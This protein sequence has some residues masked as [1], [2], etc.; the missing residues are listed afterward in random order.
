MLKLSHRALIIFSGA[1]WLAVG[2][3]LFPSGLNFL[4][5]AIE[6]S[7]KDLG[8]SYPLL[9][10]FSTLTSNREN[11]VVILIALGMLLGYSKG[12]YVLSRTAQKSVERIRSL[13][14]PT[15]LKN[16]YGA[17][18]Y[19][20]LGIMIGIGVSM[21]YLGI[22]TDVRGLID[23]AIGAALINGAMV[24]FRLAFERVKSEG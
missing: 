20:L 21:K 23:I 17:K 22:P 7:Y 6:N 16:V 11:A 2:C 24:F 3:F 18:Y 8:H 14:N 5:Q 1:I 13:P 10:F 19:L 12:R 15:E 4:L 9:Q